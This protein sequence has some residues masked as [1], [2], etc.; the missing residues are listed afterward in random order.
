MAFYEWYCASGFWHQFA[1]TAHSP[2]GL[3]PDQFEVKRV[4]QQIGTFANNDLEHIAKSGTKHEA[5]SQGLRKSL[6]NYMH[7]ICFEFSLDKWFDFKVPRTT[8]SPRF[9][10]QTLASGTKGHQTQH[11]GCLV[12]KQPHGYILCQKREK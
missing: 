7:G 9:I 8:I 1:M 5:F 2:V 3:N 10:E 12:R 6:F 4:S 11:P